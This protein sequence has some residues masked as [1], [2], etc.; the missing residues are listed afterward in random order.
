MQSLFEF[1]ISIIS[2]QVASDA[3]CSH[4]GGF[5]S[6]NIL[7]ATSIASEE[8]KV[9]LL[10][11]PVRFVDCFSGD[12]K[13]PSVGSKPCSSRIPVSFKVTPVLLFPDQ[14]PVIVMRA[15]R[16][17]AT[18]MS[19]SSF[20]TFL[21]LPHQNTGPRASS[22]PACSSAP[23]RNDNCCN[24]TES[25]SSDE[26][27]PVPMTLLDFVICECKGC[28]TSKVQAVGGVNNGRDPVHQRIVLA[29]ASSGTRGSNWD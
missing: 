10:F 22:C 2:C 26:F 12:E 6:N 13:I 1:S 25:K 21:A 18:A 29:G 9:P 14:L 15:F 7:S 24:P 28:E 5:P 17:G 16:L 23:Y 20:H 19:V 4:V 8:P 27:K 3:E 11:R